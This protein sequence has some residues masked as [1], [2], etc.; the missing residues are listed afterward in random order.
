MLNPNCTACLISCEYAG[1]SG[2]LGFSNS[3]SLTSRT[4]WNCA[5]KI[6]SSWE[7]DALD[8]GSGTLTGE[9]GDLVDFD[10]SS[11]LLSCKYAAC[12]FGA[13]KSGEMAGLSVNGPP[14]GSVGMSS[15]TAGVDGTG[16][17]RNSGCSGS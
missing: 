9:L 1:W 12:G 3:L 7:V 14:Y 10:S 17:G 15:V 11:E 6:C 13:A 16:T 2:V 4:C 8:R 5:A